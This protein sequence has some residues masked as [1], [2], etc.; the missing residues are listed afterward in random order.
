MNIY[1]VAI[2]NKDCSLGVIPKNVHD[3]K[4]RKQQ[5][6]ISELAAVTAITLLRGVKEYGRRFARENNAGSDGK[7]IKEI[8]NAISALCDKPLHTYSEDNDL[9]WDELGDFDED[10]AASGFEGDDKIDIELE[11]EDV[12]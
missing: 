10:T 12:I 5:K 9:A 11:S 8:V 4:L 1:S 2:L 3:N 6:R 7:E